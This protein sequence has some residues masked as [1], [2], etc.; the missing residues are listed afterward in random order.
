MD[1]P[2]ERRTTE[3]LETVSQLLVGGGWTGRAGSPHHHLILRPGRLQPDTLFLDDLDELDCARSR[4]VM[5]MQPVV[6]TPKAFEFLREIRDDLRSLRTGEPLDGLQPGLCVCEQ[7]VDNTRTTAISVDQLEL[8]VR[9][10]ALSGSPDGG[11]EGFSFVVLI[12]E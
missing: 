11:L 7:L 10:P 9:S 6:H 12:Q 2:P 8:V 3:T 4:L 1:A 5:T